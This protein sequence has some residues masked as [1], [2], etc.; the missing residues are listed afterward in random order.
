MALLVEVT[1][2]QIDRVNPQQ[3]GPSVYEGQV[4]VKVHPVDGTYFGGVEMSV[5]FT[6]ALSL[7]QG[8]TKALQSLREYGED[9]ARAAVEAAAQYK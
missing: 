2:V 9:L 6:H 7:N 4:T 1:G 5:P 3:G 8:V